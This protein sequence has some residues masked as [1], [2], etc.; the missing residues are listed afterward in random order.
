MS[1]SGALDNIR[2]LSELRRLRRQ[3]GRELKA[4]R[5]AAKLTQKIAAHSVGL[6]EQT[7]IRIES[8]DENVELLS[9]VALAHGLRVRLDIRLLPLVERE[10]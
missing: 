9:I 1:R 4:R 5:V 10:S 8:G 6:S 7:V 3:I 2:A